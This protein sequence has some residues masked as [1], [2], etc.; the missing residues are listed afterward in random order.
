MKL[1][2]LSDGPP[3][4]AVKMVLKY[5]NIPFEQI[6]VDYVKCEHR[7][8]SYY[9]LNPQNEIPV[10]DDDGFFLSESVAI[11]QVIYLSLIL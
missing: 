8:D 2:A 11:M 4:T 6:E 1:Y 10:L 5:L 3:S 7:T 9:K